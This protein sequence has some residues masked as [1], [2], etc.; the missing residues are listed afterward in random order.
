MSRRDTAGLHVEWTPGVVR[1]I[2]VSDGRT[3]EGTHLGDLDSVLSGGR[4]ALV[5][6]GRTAVFLKTIRLPKAAP[7]DLR[8][9]LGVQLGQHFPL[10]ADALAFDFIQTHDQNADGWLTL[11]AAVRA[12]DLRALKTVLA[13]ANLK[14]DRILPVALGAPLVAARAGLSDALVAECGPAGLSL[15]VVQDG[16]LRFSRIAPLGSDPRR[17]IQRTLAAAGVDDLPVVS[18]GSAVP[19][20]ATAVASSLALL[21]EA[22][23]FGFE[24]AEDRRHAVRQKVAART[25]MAFLMLMAGILLAALVWVDRSDAQAARTR[26]DGRWARELGSLRSIRDTEQAKASSAD[27]VRHVLDR[28]FQTAQPLSD[29]AAVVGDSLPSGVWLQ[30]LT[31]E[32][33]K[34]LQVRGTARVPEQIAQLVDRLGKD[35]RF[36][37]V[38][39]VFASGA[40]IDETPVVQ[41]TVN[42]TAVGNLP[43]PAPVR[44]GAKKPATAEKLP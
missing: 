4:D 27:A 2:R 5:G 16:L 41:F 37:D 30:G 15:D 40:K 10:P 8:R 34:P 43:L 19:G 28:A 31:L 11:I 33:G 1:A 12:D 26:A 21:H 22:P 36:R 7:D 9:I 35:V 17:E 32:R 25:R 6:I 20:A 42:A 13:Q 18:V 14:A 29:Q 23:A 3:A 39:L 44:A 24:L 38:R